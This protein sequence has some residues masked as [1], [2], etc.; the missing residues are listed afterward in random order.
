MASE[1]NMFN[2]IFQEN[3]QGVAYL[4][5]KWLLVTDSVIAIEYQY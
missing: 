1:G 2:P 5:D 4:Q 3:I